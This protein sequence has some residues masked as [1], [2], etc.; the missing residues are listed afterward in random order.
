LQHTRRSNARASFLVPVK[1]E[2]RVLFLE[3][4]KK[5]YLKKL[6]EKTQPLFKK[7]VVTGSRKVWISQPNQ[8]GSQIRDKRAHSNAGPA[9]IG[10]N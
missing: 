8:I 2:K 1:S 10:Q 4:I 9:P 5:Y 6:P 3:L 7:E